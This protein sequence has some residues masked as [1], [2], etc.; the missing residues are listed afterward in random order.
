V[1]NLGPSA[2]NIVLFH[3]SLS[4]LFRDRKKMTIEAN[5]GF[6]PTTRQLV[7]PMVAPAQPNPIVSKNRG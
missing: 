2:F 3:Q 7:N 6:S 4:R 1:E 5:H